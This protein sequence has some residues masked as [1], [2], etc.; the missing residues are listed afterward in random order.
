MIA[1]KNVKN[2]RPSELSKL[3]VALN[4]VNAALKDEKFKARVLKNKWDFTKD[5]SEEIWNNMV[6]DGSVTS[7]SIR[8]MSWWANRINKTIAVEEGGMIVLNRYFFQWQSVNSL[9]NTILHEWLHACG[10]SHA[11]ADDLDSA[12]YGIGN[13]LEV[14]LD[15]KESREALAA[16]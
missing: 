2:F 5:T 6:K 10:Y 8:T 16:L 1:L 7:L 4:L 14:Y 9:A 11:S 12:P 15:A 3:N 13:L